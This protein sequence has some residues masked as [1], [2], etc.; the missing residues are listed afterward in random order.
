MRKRTRV[1]KQMGD[2]FYLFNPEHDMALANFTPY[3]RPP[4]EIIRMKE[5]LSYLPLWYAEKGS[6]VWVNDAGI[7]EA[8]VSCCLS[9]GIRPYGI[10]SMV[11]KGEDILPWGWNPSLVNGLISKDIPAGL[12]PDKE[13]LERIRFLSGRQRCIQVMKQ[14]A[15]L[16]GICG[17]AVECLSVS[18]V[19]DFIEKTG[20]TV[21]KA[22]WSGSGRGLLRLGP[23]G[24]NNNVQGWVARIIR[25]QGGI[26]GEP[27]YDKVCDF[28]MEFYADGKGGVAFAGYSLFD[29]DAHGNYKLN[30]L[31]PDV[32]IERR[33]S[34]YVSSQGINR[35]KVHLL[36]VLQQLLGCDYCGYL[37]VDMM[38]CSV[39]GGYRIHPC[40]EINL[41]MNMGV[42][43]RLFFDRHISMSSFGQYVVEHYTIDGEALE[44]HHERLAACP[45][46]VA[47][48]GRIIHGYLSLTPVQMET[49]YQA[50]VMVEEVE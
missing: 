38:I 16:E 5:D 46:Q 34:E 43:S 13:R 17:M 47:I 9:A 40:V 33:L 41:R 18:E 8:F 50:Y 1:Q 22:P 4:R 30:F 35:I 26:M 31:L 15:G 28:A 25:S 19:R 20:E 11:W 12:C 7:S 42:V 39:D 37:G 44:K 45:L 24:W 21:L 6:K 10:S 36:S 2:F 48:D 14:L 3:Y 27:L 23:D 29:T 49:R 32:E